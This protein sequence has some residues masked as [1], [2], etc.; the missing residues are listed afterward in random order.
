MP[1]AVAA[2]VVPAAGN[3][4][5]PAAAA[6]WQPGSVRGWPTLGYAEEQEKVLNI[7]SYWDR[8]AELVV[9]VAAAGIAAGAAERERKRTVN[10]SLDLHHLVVRRGEMCSPVAA[11]VVEVVG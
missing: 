9:A 6:E 8:T 2:G 7:L 1:V 3:N 5:N 11:V 4:R 10:L